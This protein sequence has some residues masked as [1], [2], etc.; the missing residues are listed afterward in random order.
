[1]GRSVAD[2]ERMAHI[3]FGK[4]SS[5]QD[6]FPAPITYQDVTLPNKLRFGYFLNG[7]SCVTLD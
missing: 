3:L 6:Y 1:M 2:L 4:R 7:G 5:G